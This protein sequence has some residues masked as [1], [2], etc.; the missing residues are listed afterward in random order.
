M[1]G[2]FDGDVCFMPRT[3]AR[4]GA[5]RAGRGAGSIDG[6]TVWILEDITAARERNNKGLGD[7]HDALTQLFNRAA[8]DERL[9]S[10]AGRA[11]HPFAR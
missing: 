1:H 9:G 6:G 8:F 7:R 3:A 10:P 4:V 11:R 5:Y 2:A